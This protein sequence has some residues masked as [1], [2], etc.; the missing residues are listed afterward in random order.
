MLE[1]YEH[2]P[3][4]SPIPSAMVHPK[5]PRYLLQQQQQLQQ[6]QQ[7]QQQQQQQQQPEQHGGTTVIDVYR[8]TLLL[9][10][11]GAVKLMTI[12]FV[13]TVM[14]AILIKLFKTTTR[15]DSHRR[16]HTSMRWNSVFAVV[17]TTWV[18]ACVMLLTKCLWMIVNDT[19]D[20]DH[21][22]RLFPWYIFII[23]SCCIIDIAESCALKRPA[24]KLKERP[25]QL[26][27]DD[28]VKRKDI[29]MLNPPSNDDP[30]IQ[31]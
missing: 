1:D 12:C 7:L 31:A 23:I 24:K 6:L 16:H 5:V 26:L 10:R 21:V 2:Q 20:P 8:I 18:C 22:I 11:D 17:N 4:N 30:L 19:N 15:R 14:V 9:N 3:F 13:V 25:Q 27:D 29:K 28:F